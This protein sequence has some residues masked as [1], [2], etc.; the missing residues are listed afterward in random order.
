MAVLLLEK[1]QVRGYA[2]G[3]EEPFGVHIRR[4]REA[5]GLTQREMGQAAGHTESWMSNV[6]AGKIKGM[7][8]YSIILTWAT[9]LAMTPTEVVSGADPTAAL[10]SEPIEAVLARIGAF[11]A[12][13]RHAVELEQA[14][15]AGPNG[16]GAV[17]GEGPPRGRRRRTEPVRYLVRIEG[18]CLLPDARDGDFAEFEVR[19][20][21]DHG[22]LV[23]VAHD[24][25]A[26]VKYLARRGAV[27]WLL[28]LVGDPIP[29]EPG[30]RIVGVVKLFHRGPSPMPSFPHGAG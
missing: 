8:S 17:E 2:G 19:S 23:V 7:P 27:Q 6:E 10:A 28:P 29:F 12:P 13:A 15:A 22:E 25:Q 20:H 24:H 21:A 26:L 16:R 18:D 11:P 5:R 14:V 3:M 9:L 30:M 1:I 4:L